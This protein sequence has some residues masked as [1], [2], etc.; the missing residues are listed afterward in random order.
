M[1]QSALDLKIDDICWFE[2]EKST[3]SKENSDRTMGMHQGMMC[4]KHMKK[5]RTN[6]LYK[7]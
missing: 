3:H 6:F 2:D 5:Q 4:I 1:F 7:E